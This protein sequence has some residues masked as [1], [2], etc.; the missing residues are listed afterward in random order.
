MHAKVHC[1]RLAAGV[2]CQPKVALPASGL[3]DLEGTRT[4]Q[5][6]TL[7]VNLVRTEWSGRQLIAAVCAQLES[8]PD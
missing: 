4:C 8:D 7:D 5:L 2:D 6:L 1:A 3:E